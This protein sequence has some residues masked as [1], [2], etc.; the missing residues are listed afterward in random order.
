[1][2]NERKIEVLIRCKYLI[3]LG[4]AICTAFFK[5]CKRRE[6]CE[7]ILTIQYHLGSVFE[8]HKPKDKEINEL[9]FPNTKPFEQ[10][11]IEI[12]DKMI[13]ELKQMQ[14]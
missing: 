9:W 8:N 14:P 10:K 1:M 3:P 4:H 2:T 7:D 13:L 12:I 6:I 11:R 5:C